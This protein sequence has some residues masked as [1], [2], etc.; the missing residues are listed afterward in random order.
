M[1][2]WM[3]QLYARRVPPQLLRRVSFEPGSGGRITVAE[4][5]PLAA[6]GD[7]IDKNSVFSRLIPM[8]LDLSCP[9]RTAVRGLR[10][11]EGA[12]CEGVACLKRPPVGGGRAQC[13]KDAGS[14]SGARRSHPL[15]ILEMDGNQHER[16]IKFLRTAEQ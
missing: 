5:A 4:S 6:L 9:S 10:K 15:G 8:I 3:S 14:A 11:A 16:H 7:L 2:Y 13:E 12:R 1:V